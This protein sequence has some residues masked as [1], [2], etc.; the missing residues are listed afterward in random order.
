M[1]V[2]IL[3]P[4]YN[5]EKTIARSLSSLVEQTHKDFEVIIVFN[6]C[7]D[8][9]EKIA[10]S[11]QDKLK[12]KTIQCSEQGIV[13]ALN[14][15]LFSCNTKLI[16]RQDG[17]DY[18]HPTKLEKQVSFLDKNNHIDIVGTQIRLVDSNFNQISESIFHPIKDDQIKIKLLNGQNAIAHPSVLFRKKIFLRAGIYEDTYKYAEDYYQWLKCI[19]WYKFAN[20]DEILVDYTVTYNPNYDPKIPISACMNIRKILNQQNIVV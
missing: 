15:G 14:K 6:N 17:D 9:S 20:L 10:K 8:N 18:W 2:S 4:V 13:P 5:C 11:F 12:I 16:A 3:I 7:T 1:S 19:R